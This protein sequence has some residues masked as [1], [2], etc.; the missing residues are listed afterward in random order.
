MV[1]GM[2]VQII[3]N[4]LSNSVYW[5]KQK[6]KLERFTPRIDVVIDSDL[7]VISVTDNGP[8]VDDGRREEI[9]QPFVTTKPPSEGKGLGLYISREIARYNGADVEMDDEQRGPEGRLNTF[10][11][12]LGSRT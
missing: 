11:I 9:F 8:G 3:E 2:I 10:K 4:L 6:R 5:L 7:K 1:K 12:V